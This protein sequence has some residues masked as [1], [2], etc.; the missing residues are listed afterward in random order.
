MSDYF[1]ESNDESTLDLFNKRLVYRGYVSQQSGK[2][3]VEMDLHEKI[4]FGRIDKTFV[5]LKVSQQDLKNITTKQDRE[6]SLM[7]VSFVADMFENLVTQFDKCVQIGK[8]KTDDP[9]LSSLRAY[10]AY[11]DP[12]A[13]YK[14]YLQIY[15]DSLAGLLSTQNIKI[16]NFNDLINAVLPTLKKSVSEQPLTFTGFL[17]SK[18]CSVMSTGLAIEIADSSYINDLEKVETFVN[19]PNWEFYVKTC[20]EYGFI[21]DANVPWRIVAD[22]ESEVFIQKASIYRS[23]GSIFDVLRVF[24]N[25]SSD[26]G[27]RL[28]KNSM[29]RMYNNIAQPYNEITTC[30]SGKIL[31]KTINPERITPES[32]N[33][34]YPEE[35]FIEL[36][37]KMRIYEQAPHLSKHEC[38][39]IVR[40]QIDRYKAAGNLNYLHNFFESELNKTFD[41]IGSLDY[42][43][44]GSVKRQRKAFDEGTVTNITISDGT[45]DISGY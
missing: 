41:K 30:E 34:S 19:S 33:L 7:A 5:P 26:I 36:F 16:N 6:S 15:F 43:I 21:V 38:D 31:I 14:T 22:I 9:F 42:D 23:V 39:R 10:K 17:K 44:K 35:Y 11:Q 24:F 28:F 12:I 25:N 8:I 32:I 1:A 13:E 18:N 27:Y 4:L 45:G 3:V 2:N 37:I 40:K 20:N 29:I